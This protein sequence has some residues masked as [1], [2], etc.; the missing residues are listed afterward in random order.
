LQVPAEQVDMFSRSLEEA[1]E[2]RRRD[3]TAPTAAG[4]IELARWC[5]QLDLLSQAAR[6]LLDARTLDS[7]NLSLPEM[8]MRLRQMLELRAGREARVASDA[9]SPAADGE[10]MSD[11][12]SAAP[13]DISTA[14]QSQFVRRVQPMLIHGCATGGCHQP[15]SAR[16]FQLDRWAL[17]G[18]GNAVMVRRNLSAVLGQLNVETPASSPLMHWARVEHGA[19]AG[20][21]A[22]PLTAHQA[23][24]L[25]E[26]INEAAGVTPL[27]EPAVEAPV[28]GAELEAPSM[29][30]VDE[31]LADGA[32]A[33]ETPRKAF[34]PRDAFDPE[35]FN[36][37][38][39]TAPAPAAVA[40]AEVISEP[41]TAAAE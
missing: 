38:R 23:A 2:L 15:G 35:T 20:A 16:Q 40:D 12:A 33:L 28:E 29:D 31:T 24:L 19:R 3:G 11:G 41:P 22:R 21:A 14:A 26:W 30:G 37:R 25:L 4:H 18:N 36:R 10:T 32:I 1:Y 13:I 5:M 17:K 34:T 7:G 8:E 39:A 9:P 6:E 27:E